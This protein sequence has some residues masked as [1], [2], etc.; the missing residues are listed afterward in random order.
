MLANGGAER[1]ASLLSHY[2]Q[3]EGYYVHHV[4]TI[5]KIEYDYAGEVFNLGKFKNNSNYFLNKIKRFFILNNFFKKNKFDFI[6]DFRVKNN[7]IQEIIIAKYIYRSPLIVS[8]RSFNT[9]WYFPESFFLAKMIYSDCYKIISVSD[10]ITEKIKSLYGYQN[11]VTIYNPIDFDLINKKSFESF[12]VD[13]QYILALGRMDDNVKQFD[14]LIY[15]YSKSH[16]LKENIKLIIIGDG[17]LKNSLENLVISLNLNN[18]IVFKGRVDNPFKYYRNALFTVLSSKN[19]GFPN[20]LIESLA[21]QTPIVSFDC[22]S[23]PSEII[24]NGYNGLLVK[25]QDFEKLVEAINLMYEN[26]KLYMF[27]KQNALQSV[28]KFS[29]EIIGKKWIDCMNINRN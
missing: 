13:F 1:C 19:E 20:V 27:C 9:K 18:Y 15:S 2:F 10:K 16:L 24:R 4:I 22:D 25:N 23:G 11:L 21:C 8:I 26:K 7:P 5:D 29:L 28:L 14:K 12:E 3:K 17:T 6:I